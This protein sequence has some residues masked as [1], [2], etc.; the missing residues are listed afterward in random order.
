MHDETFISSVLNLLIQITS[1]TRTNVGILCYFDTHTEKKTFLVLSFFTYSRYPVSIPSAPTFQLPIGGDS[2]RQ[3]NVLLLK[4]PAEEEVSEHGAGK[5]KVKCLRIP[6]FPLVV[7]VSESVC[8]SAG[9]S[10]AR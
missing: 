10:C 2:A 5:V 8:L 4:T 3:R 9:T 7:L 6:V 1:L